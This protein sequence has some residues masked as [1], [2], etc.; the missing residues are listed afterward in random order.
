MRRG[1]VRCLVSSIRVGD[2]LVA[3]DGGLLEVASV[4]PRG[5]SIEV[6]FKTFGIVRVGSR[7]FPA[8]YFVWRM[9]RAEERSALEEDSW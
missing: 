4:S 6:G 7:R 5:D 2:E 9:R 3:G 8:D 1:Q